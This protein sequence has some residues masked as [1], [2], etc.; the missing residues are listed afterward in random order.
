MMLTSILI[1]FSPE[2]YK[3]FVAKNNHFNHFTSLYRANINLRLN[4]KR[5]RKNLNIKIFRNISYLKHESRLTR[6]K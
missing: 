6:V 3:E 4:G 1:P 5:N 2:Y